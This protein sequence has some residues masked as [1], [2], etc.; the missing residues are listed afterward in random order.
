MAEI[1]WGDILVFKMSTKN[2]VM[3]IRAMA[4]WG[5]ITLTV[6]LVFAGLGV[7]AETVYAEFY[8]QQ[9]FPG[10]RVG[11]V[12]LDGLTKSEAR[13]SV[14]KAVDQ[15]LAEGLVFVFAG[16]EARLDISIAGTNPDASRDLIRYDIDK[17]V[18]KA[19]G[20]GRGDGW[21]KDVLEQVGARLRPVRFG[22][23][24][25]VDE[26]S[27]EE[28]LGIAFKS[29]IVSAVDASFIFKL[30]DGA[31]PEVEIENEKPGVALKT[32]AALRMLKLQAEVLDFSPIILPEERTSSLLTR[33][34]L[35]P[36]KEEA[37]GFI[38]R[39]LLKFTYDGSFHT[40][41]TSTLI[42]LLTVDQTKKELALTL[43]E[44]RFLE[45]LRKLAPDI[46]QEAKNGSLDIQDGKIVSFT[47]GTQGVSIDAAATLKPVLS[48]W[49]K[50]HTF[51]LET[52]VTWG[53]L[54]G[55]DPERL[56]I[57][58]IIGVGRSNFSGSPTNRRFNI[59]KG[60][61]KVN[62]NIIA[63]G[64]EF[65]LLK[66][67]GEIDGANGWL[68]ELVIK[69]NKTIPEFGGGLCQIGTTT[70]RGAL[71]SGLKITERRNHSYRVRYYEPAGTDATIY[72]PI[73]DFKFVN[74]TQRHILINAYTK[75]DNAIF[76]FWGTKDGRQV[77]PI[78]PRI[79]N[80]ASPPPTKLIETTDL[81]PGKKKCTESA[82]AGADAEFMYR[83]A[84]ADGT[85]HEEVFK[86]HYRP[87]QAVCLIGVEKVSEPAPGEEGAGEAVSNE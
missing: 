41:P 48:D 47:P 79:Y 15:A 4:I 3:A 8:A 68:P 72:D 81:E 21:R 22:A 58:E 64:E 27:I 24:A 62:G 34:H 85:K 52:K 45:A 51:P 35:E 32:T 16:Q 59:K 40:L 71:D 60:A 44:T 6:L 31:A 56:G 69:E 63:P 36:L 20:I 74:D 46:E 7:A 54:V 76:E 66:T 73:P 19:Y 61:S 43:D 70:F 50:K 77:D 2:G 13:E 25:A 23:E 30:Q 75:G 37:E 67:L 53:S 87:W 14:Q 55:E 12:R 78:K 38:Q 17:A 57:R 18:E 9:I 11:T 49:P 86:S 39:P 42:N 1:S 84:Y 28:A 83:I 65:S 10:V 82:H 33:R 29:K 26:R 80:I 5:G